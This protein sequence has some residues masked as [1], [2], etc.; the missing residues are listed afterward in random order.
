MIGTSQIDEPSVRAFATQSLVSTRLVLTS[1][2]ALAFCCGLLA[3]ETSSSA[4][5][6]P[7]TSPVSPE[8]DSGAGGTSSLPQ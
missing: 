5:A 4:P 1:S 8:T 7:T 3:C 6:D 2:S